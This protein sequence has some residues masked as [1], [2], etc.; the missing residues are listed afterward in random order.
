MVFILNASL[1]SLGI[2]STEIGHSSVKIPPE[3]CFPENDPDSLIS[4]VFNDFESNYSDESYLS[5]RVILTTTHE[6]VDQINAAL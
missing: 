1:F 4:A 5:K 3:L 6:N 2:L